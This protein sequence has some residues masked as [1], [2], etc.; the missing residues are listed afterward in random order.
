MQ[1]KKCSVSLVAESIA[2]F[3]PCKNRSSVIAG[4]E[5]ASLYPSS[6]TT[7]FRRSWGGGGDTTGLYSSFVTVLQSII[8]ELFW[9][10]DDICLAILLTYC[11]LK[12][13]TEAA[14]C[15]KSLIWHSVF[16]MSV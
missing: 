1:G 11:S 4:R 6:L 12:H 3:R 10:G 5:A 13:V 2:T 14:L 7:G 9:F 16:Q 8:L 15:K